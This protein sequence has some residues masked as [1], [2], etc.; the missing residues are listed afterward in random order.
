MAR[1]WQ[2]HQISQSTPCTYSMCQSLSCH[3]D[4]HQTYLCLCIVKWYILYWKAHQNS[5]KRVILYIVFSSCFHNCCIRVESTI[6][7]C[8]PFNALSYDMSYKSIAYRVQ[9]CI[10]Y[11]GQSKLL[12]TNPY[13]S[14]LSKCCKISGVQTCCFAISPIRKL[15]KNLFWE[16]SRSEGNTIKLRP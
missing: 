4:T 7:K 13:Y 3:M 9:Y 15:E 1:C 10:N 2:C 8:K 5:T 12:H 11:C 16:D 6:D 14:T